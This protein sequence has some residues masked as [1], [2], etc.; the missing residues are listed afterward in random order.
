MGEAPRAALALIDCNN[1]YVSCERV[2]DPRLRG[3]PVGVLSNNDGC[4]IARSE[5]LK[6]LGVRMGTPAFQVRD[7]IRR[8]RV[9]VLSSNYAL[10]GSMSA[11]VNAVLTD[12]APAAEAYSIDET[13][14]DLTGIAGRDLRPLCQ[15]LR[16]TVLRWTGIPTCVGLGPSKTL[17]KLANAAAKADPALGGVCDLTEASVCAAVLAAFPV[18]E[19]WGVG[20][21]TAAKL[22]ALGVTTAAGLRDFDPKQARALGTVVLERLVWELRGLACLDLELV[23]PPRKGLAVTRSFGRPVTALAEALEA[24]AAHA[25]RAAEKLRTHGLVAGR[26]SAFAH[27]APHHPGPQHHAARATGLVP[28]T[29][30]TRD[31]VAAAGRCLAAAWRDGFAYAKAGVVLEDLC[32][33]EAAPRT[34]FDAPRPGSA[35][36]MAAV[37]RLN[38]RFGHGTVFP[39][40][41]GT[42][43]VW[44]QRAAHRSP[45]YTTRLDELPI[46]RA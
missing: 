24:V 44:A 19:V 22:A 18:A 37:D 39:A 8:H 9:R 4:F 11:R 10:Y 28:M 17:A 25:T 2:F 3:V 14:L 20:P 32:P 46:A 21:A 41:A 30:D 29:A 35:R 26:L 36:L 15:D 31:L 6:A 45:R 34:L 27:T 16:A 43:R 12:F 42:E 33:P 7:L 38:A 5:E 1:F 23:A 13:F 40:A